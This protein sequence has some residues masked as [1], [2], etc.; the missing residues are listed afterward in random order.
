MAETPTVDDGAYQTLSELRDRVDYTGEELFQ[1]NEQLRFDHLLVRL[2][3]E[4]R[5]IFETLWGDE[6]PVTE[7]GRTDRRRATGD[8]AMQLIYPIQEVTEVE[9]RRSP[10][11]DWQTL[12]SDR[13]THTDHHLILSDRPVNRRRRNGNSLADNANR[14]EWGDLASE[15]RV[16]YDRGFGDQPSADILSIQVALVNRMLRHLRQEQTIASSSPEDFAGIS[17]EF[18]TVV[19]DEIRDRVGDV[20]SPGMASFT[21]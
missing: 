7:T 5:K 16:T 14:T 12:D 18:D 6:T 21:I 1:D 8:A 2:E 11:S 3:R 19:T 4:S 15:I 20:T 13:W 17:V 10:G 9:Y